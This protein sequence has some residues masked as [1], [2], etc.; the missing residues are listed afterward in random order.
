MCLKGLSL[1][2][3]SFPVRE[4]APDGPIMLSHCVKPFPCLRKWFPDAG[5]RFPFSENAFP[6]WETAFRVPKAD[7]R[8]GKGF[9]EVRGWF[10]ESGKGGMWLFLS[11]YINFNDIL[12]SL[13][14]A[15]AVLFR[16]NINFHRDTIQIIIPLMIILYFF[17]LNNKF[18]HSF[19]YK[20]R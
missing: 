16:F 8:C 17:A 6:M 2:A 14:T 19:L 3:D 18:L 1:A 20:C 9:S 7:S 11:S 15:V 5:D 10:P 13:I 4:T 12:N